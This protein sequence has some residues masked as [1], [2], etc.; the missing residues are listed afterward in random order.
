V[1]DLGLA[2]QMARTSMIALARDAD[3]AALKTMVPACPDWAVKDLVGHVT[4]IAASLVAGQIPED[5]KN[6]AMLWDQDVAAARNEF[7]DEQIEFRRDAPIDQI[8]VGESR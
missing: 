7:I 5:L 8:G 2:Y 6:L 4:S 3:D 1:P